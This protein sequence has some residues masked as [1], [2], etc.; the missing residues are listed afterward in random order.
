[1]QT[2]QNAR[3]HARTAPSSGFDG[4]SLRV[5]KRG[6]IGMKTKEEKK[7]RFKEE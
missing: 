5:R 3:Q 1:M 7:K 6:T 2:F 4:W